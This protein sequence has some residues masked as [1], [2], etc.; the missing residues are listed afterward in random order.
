[1][2]G[3][4]KEMWLASNKPAAGFDPYFDTLINY[5]EIQLRAK[6]ERLRSLGLHKMLFMTRRILTPAIAIM[7]GLWHL[8]RSI[9]QVLPSQFW[10]K[11]VVVVVPHIQ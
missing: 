3:P 10:R 2:K 4:M 8:H 7:V 9:D 1:M 5:V 6:L 11:M